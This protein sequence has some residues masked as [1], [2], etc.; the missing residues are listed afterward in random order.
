[1]PILKIKNIKYLVSSVLLENSKI[2][3]FDCSWRIYDS[4]NDNTILFHVFLF[5]EINSR[6]GE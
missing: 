5:Y 1:M 2:E 3:G 4:Y 6:S